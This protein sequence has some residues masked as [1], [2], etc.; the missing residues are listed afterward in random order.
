MIIE[1]SNVKEICRME[2]RIIIGGSSEMEW[3]LE[4]KCRN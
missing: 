4:A 3:G 1:G 2:K